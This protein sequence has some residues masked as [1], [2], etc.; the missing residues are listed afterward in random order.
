MI[1]ITQVMAEYVCSQR[2]HKVTYTIKPG[3]K[4]S[5][6]GSKFICERCFRLVEV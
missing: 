6:V 4:F 5:T 1:W 3:V 2:G